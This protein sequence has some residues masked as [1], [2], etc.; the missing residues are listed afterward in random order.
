M[1]NLVTK[2]P[3]GASDFFFLSPSSKNE[4][5]ESWS[6]SFVNISCLRG[7]CERYGLEVPKSLTAEDFSFLK[8]S[9]IIHSVNSIFALDLRWHLQTNQAWFWWLLMSPNSH[10]CGMSPRGRFLKFDDSTCIADNWPI[11]RD[12]VNLF[13][14]LK[15]SE[16]QIL[17]ISEILTKKRHYDFRKTIILICDLMS[18]FSVYNFWAISLYYFWYL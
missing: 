1:G 10:A 6:G 9:T 7:L 8:N 16:D 12:F 15:F 17:E 3:P 4:C 5:G 13:C 18:G 2:K 14:S 11:F